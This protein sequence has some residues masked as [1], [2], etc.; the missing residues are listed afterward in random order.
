MKVVK[1]KIKFG[2][3]IR[4]VVPTRRIF[5]TWTQLLSGTRLSWRL[6][7]G[8]ERPK[9][10]KHHTDWPNFPQPASLDNSKSSD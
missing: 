9:P 5:R 3:E 10:F 8:A 6:P 4:F 1:L 2:K 7:A